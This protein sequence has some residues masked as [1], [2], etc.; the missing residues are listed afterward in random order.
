MRYSYVWIIFITLLFAGC[1]GTSQDEAPPS[2]PH[3]NDSGK[4]PPAVPHID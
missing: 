4:I 2:S 3:A 1:G